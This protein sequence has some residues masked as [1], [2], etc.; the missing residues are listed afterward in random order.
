MRDQQENVSVISRLDQARLERLLA[1]FD[2]YQ[3]PNYGPL[4]QPA[5]PNYQP[6]EAHA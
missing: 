4:L 3:T 1:E 6:A 2:P 5:A